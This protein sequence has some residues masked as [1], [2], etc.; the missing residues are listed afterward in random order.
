MKSTV[1]SHHRTNQI[2][3][4]EPSSRER[5][6]QQRKGACARFFT[7]SPRRSRNNLRNHPPRRAKTPTIRRQSRAPSPILIDSEDVR[8]GRSL[9]REPG[10]VDDIEGDHP[11]VG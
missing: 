9:V 11:A 1:V 2:T 8:R 10:G 3:Y 4:G 6:C 7:S 5:T